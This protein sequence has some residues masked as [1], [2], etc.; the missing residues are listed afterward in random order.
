MEQSAKIADLQS[1]VIRQKLSRCRRTFRSNLV[2]T[3]DYLSGLWKGCPS[4]GRNRCQVLDQLLQDFAI[5][6]V[7]AVPPKRWASPPGGAHPMPTAPL[8]YEG[9]PRV[10]L[11]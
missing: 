9:I 4:S 6:I 8:P 1:F 5:L 7:G 10:N 11:F 3:Q 2:R